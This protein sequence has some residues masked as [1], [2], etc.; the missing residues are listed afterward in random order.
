MIASVAIPVC[1]FAK[2][3]V[4]SEVKTRLIPVLGAAN[5][6]QLASAMLLDVWRTVESCPGVRSILATT[7]L[8]EFPMSVSSNDCWL[9]GDGDLGQR[10]DRI[11][12][13]ALR[14]CP[15][16]IAVGADSP[17]LTTAHL[18]AALDG[19]KLNDAVIG[20]SLDGGFY[21]LGL[22]RCHSG[23]FRSIPWSSE[24][25]CQVLRSNL[26]KEKFA[27]AELDPLCDVDEP[28]DLL[29]LEKQLAA[30]PFLA[31]ATRAWHLQNR[32]ALN[33]S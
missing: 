9:Q 32:S 6:A 27:V 8:G 33:R 1:I 5:A 19:L 29:F 22:K 21:L 23:L 26:R 18:T 11:L 3:P 20:P 24:Q 7:Q 4:P 10:I 15:A 12:R 16:A 30:D 31:P 14:D 17:G 28:G 2:P 25:T 13:R